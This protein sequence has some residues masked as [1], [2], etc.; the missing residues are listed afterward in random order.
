MYPEVVRE[1]TRWLDERGGR[2]SVLAAVLRQAD[3]SGYARGSS[4][5]PGL[6]SPEE[7]QLPSS[8]ASPG[9]FGTVKVKLPSPIF[10]SADR[11]EP[12]HPAADSL[13]AER[14]GK[15]SHT[16]AHPGKILW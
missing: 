10:S 13:A 16:G 8:A 3:G 4:W 7:Q 2:G 6:G 1:G 12:T 14:H 11:S 15:L 9:I 5:C